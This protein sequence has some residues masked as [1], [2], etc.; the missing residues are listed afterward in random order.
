MAWDMIHRRA[1]MGLMA[2]TA[3][4]LAGCGRDDGITR[5]TFW[6]MGN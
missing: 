1:A 3:A 2:G 4:A 6:A 5:L